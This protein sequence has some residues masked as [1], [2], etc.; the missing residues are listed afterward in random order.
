MGDIGDF[1]RDTKEFRKE[2][3]DK[4]KYNNLVNS[5]ALLDKEKIPYEV[6][7]NGIHYVVDGRIDYWPT[8]GKFIVRSNKK[9]GRGIFNLLK[10]IKQ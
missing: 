5:T 8:T 4:R 1:F 3:S 10:E 9:T 6:K 2:E 7:N